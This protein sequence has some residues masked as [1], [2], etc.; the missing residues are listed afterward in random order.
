VRSPSSISFIIR[1]TEE[2]SLS[3]PMVCTASRIGRPARRNAAIWRERCMTSSFLIRGPEISYCRML[4]LSV[5]RRS[6]SSFSYRAI[7]ASPRLPAF[8]VPLTVF[9]A[10]VVPT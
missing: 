4:F 9:P 7:S 10:S 8:S 2:L 5:T 6:R 1:R 3:A